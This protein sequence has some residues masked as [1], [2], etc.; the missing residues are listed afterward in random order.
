LD[1]S[2]LEGSLRLLRAQR[3]RPCRRTTDKRN[4]L[5]PPHGVTSPILPSC[6]QDI[7]RNSHG[8][9]GKG[10]CAATATR[11]RG[12]L[13]VNCG[14]SALFAAPPL[15]RRQRKFKAWSREVSVC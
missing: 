6:E 13:R 14:P 15:S 11:G 10:Y 1:V 3:E 9:H 5:P 2:D 8:L 7:T 4:E 12:R